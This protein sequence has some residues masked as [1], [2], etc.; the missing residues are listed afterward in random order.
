MHDLTCIVSKVPACSLLGNTNVE[1]RPVIIYHV[2][3]TWDGHV[4]D[5]YFGCHGT[6][7][8]YIWQDVVVIVQNSCWIYIVYL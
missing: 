1:G 8:H 6:H 5:H 2:T 7:T 3:I 4:Q